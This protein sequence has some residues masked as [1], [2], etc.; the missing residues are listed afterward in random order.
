MK[1]F[2]RIKK[3][4]FV[5]VLLIAN[6]IISQQLYETKKDISYY[7]ELSVTKDNYK[8]SKCMLDLYYPKG[9]KDFATIV[10]FH[11]GG[12]TSG[13]K[14]IPQELLDKGYAVVGAEYRLS[15]KV[16]SP[17]YIEDAA[18]AVAWVFKHIIEFGGNSNLIFL[19]GH[20]AGGYLDLMISL[21][22]K[23]LQKYNINA[24]SIAGVIPLSPQVITHFTVRKE[25]GIENSQPIIDEFAP[26][27]FVRGDAP[28]ILL[29]TGDPEMELFGRYEENL[30]FWR[31][32]K[33]VGNK[34]T[35]LN[36][37]D[38]FDHGNMVKPGIL[39]LLNEV[40]KIVQERNNL[41]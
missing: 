2:R 14:E 24:N 32:M 27:Y 15:P 6:S 17:V 19:S 41:K 35:T 20:S 9:K 4:I 37:L 12:L 21:D 11:G 30:Y 33:L 18:A 23:Y 29:V 26:L 1:L 8:N 13:K 28:R 10:W 16:N 31:M 25:Y 7:E 34:Q 36:K 40:H 22:K 5:I 3:V 39:L 38:G